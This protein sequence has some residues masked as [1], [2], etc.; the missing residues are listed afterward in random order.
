M[1]TLACHSVRKRILSLSFFAR[2]TMLLYML[3]H[4]YATWGNR[5]SSN[6]TVSPAI[7]YGGILH[8]RMAKKSERECDRGTWSWEIERTVIYRSP[9]RMSH[10]W[11]LSFLLSSKR[12][13]KSPL[14]S[15]NVCIFFS[16]I[17]QRFDNNGN[18]LLLE[19]HWHVAFSLFIICAFLVDE[20]NEF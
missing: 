4:M 16:Q 8:F 9:D 13:Q 2:A 5:H 20:L 1:D 14:K 11:L 3:W 15:L 12:R 19:I 18:V 6:T 17:L 10:T 7:A